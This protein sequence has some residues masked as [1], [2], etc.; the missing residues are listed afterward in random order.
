MGQ[1]IE[2]TAEDGHTFAVYQAMPSGT[3]RGAMLVIQEI[4]GVNQH[5]RAV[6]DSYA[7]EGFAVMAPCLYDRAERGFEV[8]YV[9]DDIA[10]G[11]DVRALVPWDDA[12]KDMAA[13]VD[14]L[15]QYGK[16]GSVGYCW[17]GSLSWL[18]ATRIDAVAGSVCYYGGQ[19]AMYND[20]QAQNPVLM[21]FGEHDH[22]IPM[23]DVDK[24]KAA[25]PDATVH[26]YPAGHGFNCDERGDFD[27]DS[28]KTA[29]ERSLAFFA[30]HVG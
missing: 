4:F 17:G 3:P 7:A 25:H 24:I 16:V 2:L 28:A 19:I 5:I 20:E 27:A 22:G 13:T 21:H 14:A 11:R 1:M 6:A 12:V 15:K 10:R 26:I 8:G 9:P 30:E 18:A 29:W 23:E